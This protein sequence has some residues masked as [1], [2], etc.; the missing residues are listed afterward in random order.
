MENKNGWIVPFRRPEAD[1]VTIDRPAVAPVVD[2][3]VVGEGGAARRTLE[4]LRRA[5]CTIGHRAAVI[6]AGPTLRLPP[7]SGDVVLL[8]SG[9]EVFKGWLDR[10]HAAA[11][12]DA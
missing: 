4:S 2:V 12:A 10:L 11:Y 7:G 8:Q 9:S 5:R 3:L 1:L 6:A